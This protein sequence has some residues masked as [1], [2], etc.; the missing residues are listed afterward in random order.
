MGG[1][2]EQ[3][4]GIILGD[5]TGFQIHQMVIT[6]CSTFYQERKWIRDSRR[7]LKRV[8][9]GRIIWR[10]LWRLQR[11][12]AWN[13]VNNERKGMS[14]IILL[15]DSGRSTCVNMRTH[16]WVCVRGC[17]RTCVYWALTL[18]LAAHINQRALPLHP[19]FYYL[20]H[21]CNFLSPPP[22]PLLHCSSLRHGMG[23]CQ[24]QWALY[25]SE[26]VP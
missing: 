7:K 19:L 24:S 25:Y 14:Q 12:T 10:F 17:A 1:G 15:V 6:A 5:F 13:L 23:I 9:S 8:C 26:N 18:L 11:Q 16:G 4:E 2:E 3:I 20:S 22:H 21:F